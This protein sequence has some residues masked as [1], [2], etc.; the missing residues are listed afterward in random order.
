M[1]NAE[2]P[3]LMMGK[4]FIRLVDEYKKYNSLIIAVDFDDTLFDFHKK[5]EKYNN[6]IKLIQDLKKLNCYIIIWTG[7]QDVKFVSEYC[8]K[9]DIPFDSI[10]ED[11]PVAKELYL[12]NNQSAPRKIYANVYLDDRSG[13]IQMYI[14]LSYLVTLL[15]SE[16][17]NKKTTL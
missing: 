15:N 7:N 12:K 17:F 5:G 3:Y 4:N 2:D 1:N 10:N 16:E 9:N 8:N 14:E 13:L 11:S 6:L